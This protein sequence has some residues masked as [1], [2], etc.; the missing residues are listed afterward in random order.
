VL[1][2]IRRFLHFN[3]HASPKT[4]SSVKA[5]ALSARFEYEL[6]FKASKLKTPIKREECGMSQISK[7][8]GILGKFLA[9]GMAWGTKS[10]YKNTARIISLK[11]DDR[12]LEIGFGS[13]LF[14]KKYASHV[15]QVSGIDFSKDMVKLASNNNKK[16]VESGKVEFIQGV[17]SALP[18]KDNQ[19]SV[20]VG[21]ETFFF[22]SEPKTSLEEI[23]RVL[24]PGGRLVIE[25]AYNKD[26]GKDHSQLVEKYNLKLYGGDE[27]VRLL[28]ESGFSAVCIRYYKSLWVPFKGNIV[29]KGMIVK[30]EKRYLE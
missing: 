18:W 9:W 8:A 2:A 11:N 20:A 3:R 24:V 13:G 16:L 26:D 17:A 4:E 7:P 15:A 10:F 12:Y 28:E 19:F 27:M 25:M 21:I 30:A 6:H 29:P 5:I 23:H 14:I 1:L 22:W